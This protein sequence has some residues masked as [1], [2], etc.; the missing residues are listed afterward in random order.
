LIFLSYIWQIYTDFQNS[1]TVKI[2][3]E[4]LYICYKDFQS[5]LKCVN[6]LTCTTAA[7]FSGVCKRDLR[8]HLASFMSL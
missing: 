7:N 8:I 3:K 2:P 4:I 6:D 1:L 5:H